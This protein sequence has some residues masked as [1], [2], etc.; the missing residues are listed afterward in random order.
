MKEEKA[1]YDRTRYSIYD[2]WHKKPSSA[3]KE[4]KALHL[5]F[6]ELFSQLPVSVLLRDPMSST[7]SGSTSEHHGS[8]EHPGSE[9]CGSNKHRGFE[10]RGSKNQ[11]GFT[12]HQGSTWLRT[13]HRVATRTNIRSTRRT[14]PLSL[15]SL[16]RLNL[17]SLLSIVAGSC[18]TQKQQPINR[19]ACYYFIIR[20]ISVDTTAPYFFA[21]KYFRRNVTNPNSYKLQKPSKY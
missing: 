19:A 21:Y 14:Y 9:H 8:T 2:A 17:I 6:E 13:Q 20:G 7:L 10:Y 5:Q 15:N 4:E 18:F 1:I 16:S 12:E 3:M 11:Q